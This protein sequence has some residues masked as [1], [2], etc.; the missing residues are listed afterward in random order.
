MLIIGLDG[1]T[2]KVIKP[3][4]TKLPTFNKLCGESN[5]KTIV[6]KDSLISASVWCSMFSGKPEEEHKHTNF[7]INNVVQERKDIKVD[8]IWDILSKKGIDIRALSIPLIYPPYNFN[9][10]FTPIRNG[11]SQELSD[12]EIDLERT[13]RKAIEILKQ[14]PDIFIVVYNM[15]DR[16]S[17]IHWGE[18]ILLDFYQKID[19]ALEQLIKF[20][21]KIIIISDHGFCDWEESK[22]H[23][24]TKK[25]PKG[26]IIKGDHHPEAILITKNIN[27]EI[28]KPKDIF[29]SI[30]EECK[31]H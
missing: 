1:A 10:D 28:N 23:T 14:K 3:N 11:L 13:T 29:F 20:D 12:I 17:H 21:D 6:V 24:L 8:F 31:T 4:L 9:C 26:K 16:M 2:W 18:K 19:R 15:I 22:V 27:Y 7:I 25:T 5:H 30:L